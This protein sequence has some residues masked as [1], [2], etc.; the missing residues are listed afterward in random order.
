MRM[1]LAWSRSLG[2]MALL[3]VQPAACGNRASGVRMLDAPASGCDSQSGASGPA[4]G[5][6]GVLACLDPSGQCPD[7]MPQDLPDGK[8]SIGSFLPDGGSGSE[9]PYEDLYSLGW[10]VRVEGSSSWGDPE[11][12]GYFYDKIQGTRVDGTS[13]C[14]VSIGAVLRGQVFAVQVG[15]ILEIHMGISVGDFESGA[16]RMVTVRDVSGRLLLAEAGGQRPEPWDPQ[17]LPEFVVSGSEA[18]LCVAGAPGFSPTYFLTVILKGATDTC[19]IAAH[20]SGC[21]SFGGV[22][23]EVS[24]V[25]AWRSTPGVN[26]DATSLDVFVVARDFVA[27]AP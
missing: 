19:A 8:V 13:P 1:R 16:S 11:H 15:E 23:F 27:P 3:L 17:I 25:E 7:S 22:T 5:T 18:P 4:C 2:L 12:P 24:A 14:P 20:T 21:C 6:N 10:K 26:V 9:C